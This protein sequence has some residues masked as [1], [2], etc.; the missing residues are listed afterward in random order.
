MKVGRLKEGVVLQVG[1]RIKRETWMAT[2]WH[3]VVRIT[4]KFAIVKWNDK[5]EGK[6]RR[7]VLEKGNVREA[8]NYD[9]WSRVTTT[10]WR[11]IKDDGGKEVDKD[12]QT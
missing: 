10:A 5:A 12:G 9:P 8:G 7:V 4:S 1:D 3:T 6:F 11:P 2:S